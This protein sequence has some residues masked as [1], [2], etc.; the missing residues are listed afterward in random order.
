M[1]LYY[2]KGVK[3]GGKKTSGYVPAHTDK[4]AE[5]NVERLAVRDFTLKKVASSLGGIEYVVFKDV[6]NAKLSQKNQAYFFEQLSFLLRSGLTLFQC[7]DIMAQSSNVEVAKL[8]VKLKP[9]IVSGLSLD[10]AMKKTGMFSYDTLAKIEAGRSSGS[11]TDTLDMIA[12]K[13]KKSL[14]LRSKV[15]SSL[16]Y[17]AFMVLMLIAVLILMLIV[18]VPSIAETITQLGGE[19]PGLT[20]FII[21]A[22]N[23]VLNYGLYVLIVL[24][25]LIGLHIYLMKNITKYRF[26]IHTLIYK[27]PIFGAISMKLNVQ[28]LSNTLSQLLVSGVT[29]ANALQICV[30]TIP[31]LKMKDAVQ[32]AY[33][34]VSQDGY[35]VYSAFESTKFFPIDFVQM[36]MIGSHSGNLDG[37]LS[38]VAD[39]YA[40][41]VEETLKRLTAL[42]EPLAI[43]LTAIIGGVCVVAMYLPMFNVFEAI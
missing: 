14:E 24:G 6:S 38:S 34:R 23:A 36:I 43:M 42:V 41:E 19:M 29:I 37:I 2:Y 10:E 17:P 12:A 22:S 31:N 32:K 25:L 21:N 15:I 5:R 13:I 39:Q 4:E 30:K 11:L 40:K 27:L 1:A 28:T 16:T 20:L 7:I 33:I 3:G 35:D 9:S 18:I 8:A 26:L